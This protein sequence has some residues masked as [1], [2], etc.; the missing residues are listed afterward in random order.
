M[1]QNH[2]GADPSQG[3]GDQEMLQGQDEMINDPSTAN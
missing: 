3:A 2:Q 1:S